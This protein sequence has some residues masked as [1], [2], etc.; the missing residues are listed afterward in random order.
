LRSAGRSDGLAGI[1]NNGSDVVHT[2]MSVPRENG[3]Q[4]AWPPN[5]D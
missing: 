5:V 1:G 4:Y 2:N 3:G